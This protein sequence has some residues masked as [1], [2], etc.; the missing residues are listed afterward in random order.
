MAILIEKQSVEYH[1]LYDE[2]CHLMSLMRLKNVPER[3]ILPWRK[4][5][6]DI[7]NNFIFL[8]DA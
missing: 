7:S 4:K 3:I 2:G 6:S 5:L 1:S 8:A